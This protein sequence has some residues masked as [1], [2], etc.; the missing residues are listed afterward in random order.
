MADNPFV[1]IENS[2]NGGDIRGKLNIIGDDSDISF[3][4]TS[5][6]AEIENEIG[7]FITGTIV[8]AKAEKKWYKYNGTSWVEETDVPSIERLLYSVIVEIDDTDSPYS[9]LATDK[10][11]IGDTGSGDITVGL[12]TIASITGREYKIKNIGAGTLTVDAHLAETIDG[13]LDI[14]LSEDESINVIAASSGW[15]II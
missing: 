7:Y 5:E 8:F 1:A 13:G 9:A 6:L 2:D 15:F 12:P 11:I 10:V 3:R 4:Y 14:A